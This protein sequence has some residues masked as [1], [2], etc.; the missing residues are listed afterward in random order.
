MKPEK[1]YELVAKMRMKQSEYFKTK[2]KRVFWEAI[3]LEKQVDAEIFEHN[4]QQQL[5]FES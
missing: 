5:N 3:E 2:N 1:F 4:Y